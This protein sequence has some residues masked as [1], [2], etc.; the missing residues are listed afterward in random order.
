MTSRAVLAYIA[1]P[2]SH[3]DELIKRSRA[4]KVTATAAHLF[5]QGIFAFSP[6]TLNTSL[7]EAGAKAGWDAWLS[8]DLEILS[9]CDKLIVLKL[10]GWEH[11]AGVKAEIAHAKAL[12]IP[13]EEMNPLE[14]SG[15]E[16]ANFLTN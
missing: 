2:Y 13:I 16:N 12:G 9:R 3:P 7:I 4:K 10:P 5:N 6:I 8:Y 15:S 11:S 1:C 14:G